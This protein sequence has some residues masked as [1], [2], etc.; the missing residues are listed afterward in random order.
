MG[1]PFQQKARQRK[2]IY[3]GLIVVLFTV[4]LLHRRLIVERQA[5]NLQLREA[6]RGE[7]ELTSS[8][9]RLSLTGS[10]G[11]ATTVLWSMAMDR[12]MRHEWNEL[13]LLVNSISALQPYFITPWVF[14]SWNL[15]FNVAVE[16]DRPHDKYYY[17][18]RG[19]QLLAEGERRNQGTKDKV[20]PGSGQ[21]IFPGNPEMR[22]YMGFY[23]QLKIGNSDERNTM[24]SL[25]DLSCIDPLQRKPELFRHGEGIDT[26][27]NRDKFQQFCQAHPRLV[28]RLR[29]QLGYDSPQQIV[30]FLD[31]NR[32]VPSRFQKPAVSDQK[33]SLLEEP[34]KQ[35]PILPP[36]KPREAG[37]DGP[38]WPHPLANPMTSETIDVFLVCRTWYQYAQE[39][40]PPP[41]REAGAFNK[42]REH[43]E[44]IERDRKEKNI[45]YRPSKTMAI[46]IFRGY[47]ARGQLYIAETLEGEGWF[48][49]EG[50]LIK[51]WFDQAGRDEQDLQVGTETKYHAQP[52]WQTAY[53]MYMNYGT[54][55]GM[56]L[57]PAET[58]DLE[59]KGERARTALK[60]P[61]GAYPP[62]IPT[63]MR[64]E[65]GE[66]YEALQQL[67][68]NGQNRGMTNYD[69]H[70]Y[71]SEAEKDSDTILARKLLFHALQLKRKGQ[72]EALPLFVQAWPLWIDV[73]L[74][75]PQF[76]QVSFVQD[77][78]YEAMLHYM[79]LEQGANPQI[80]QSAM[81]NAA[82]IAVLPN[83][84]WHAWIA[85][86]GCA[87]RLDPGQRAKIAPAVRVAEGPLELVALYDGPH[88]KALRDYWFGV[89]YAA[90]R[91][92]QAGFAPPV[93]MPDQPNYALAGAIWDRQP[94]AP[95]MWRYLIA[96][97]VVTNV[98]QRL[99]LIS[100]KQEA[101][102]P[103]PDDTLRSKK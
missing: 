28:R 77:D 48:D 31:A 61:A 97:E 26:Q 10:R 18:S 22:F 40:L 82:Q 24:R 53:R 83:P 95:K 65:L 85:G 57:S 60:V 20:T 37:E 76:N 23:H 5:E 84:T 55:T 80:F 9:V 87:Q 72:Q 93:P 74:R 92:G 88:A 63:K 16:C 79:R 62:P 34:R 47:P 11:L 94:A 49:R 2:V 19:L 58:T 7:V 67:A 29:E 12:M 71:T 8:F 59:R 43:Q 13:E 98:R 33:E 70:L 78:V 25:F 86:T 36:V 39:P 75:Y 81:A 73:W 32:D 44:M 45:N 38:A 96:P 66:S 101:P 52:A 100:A 90:S 3:L 99:G 68:R 51:G 35:F 46:E 56:Y 1:N 42:E 4:S 14:Q 50:W 30:K 102:V 41:L 54:R 89:T 103:P 21:P 27:I 64:E 69:A 15:A 6:V 17:V 91:L